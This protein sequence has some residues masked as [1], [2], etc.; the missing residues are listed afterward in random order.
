M[1]ASEL[2]VFGLLSALTE[3]DREALAELL[4]E[5]ELVDGK[6]AFREG[7]EGEGLLLLVRGQLNLKSNR[8]GGDVGSITAPY[9]LGALS[10]FSPGQREVTAVAE[11]SCL[12]WQLSRSGL[13]RLSVD[14]PRAAFRIAEATVTE[15]AGLTRP[16]LG[17]M[18][19]Y[20]EK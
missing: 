19:E 3:E 17:S 4:E 9:H 6:S 18:A 8:H 12:I 16:V 5:T 10:L 14:C 7:S 2:K 20:G 1:R 15:I 11:G 13:S